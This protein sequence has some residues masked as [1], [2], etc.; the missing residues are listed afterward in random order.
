MGLKDIVTQ[1]RSGTGLA[2][3]T[4][5]TSH[6]HACDDAPSA[7]VTAERVCNPRPLS[8][9]TEGAPPSNV[10]LCRYSDA[11]V[12]CT[13]VVKPSPSVLSKYRLDSIRISL[14]ADPDVTWKRS[15][16]VCNTH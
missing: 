3:R 6:L 14:S 9:T 12:A 2:L 1:R 7:K 15:V 11:V 4:D 13:S 16:D 10:I 5:T 8:A